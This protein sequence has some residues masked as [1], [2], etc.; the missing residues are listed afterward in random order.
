[1]I[2]R[3][4]PVRNPFQQTPRVMDAAGDLSRR[5]EEQLVGSVSQAGKTRLFA[6]FFRQLP[7]SGECNLRVGG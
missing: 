7:V 6:V 2:G 4:L 5:E 3:V 1:M